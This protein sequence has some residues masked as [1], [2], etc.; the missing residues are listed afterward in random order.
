MRIS[1]L[2][3]VLLLALS[4]RAT[5]QPVLMTAQEDHQRIMNLLHIE[6]LRK[7]ADGSHPDAPNAANY[8][9]TKAKP[10]PDLPD[11]LT[12]RN[13]KKVATARAWWDQ[14]RPQIVEDFDREIYGRVPAVTPSVQWE[15]TATTNETVGDIPVV[16]KK[17]TGHVDNPAYPGIK[18]DIQ[19]SLSTPPTRPARFR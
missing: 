18:V 17:L 14:R 3:L 19:V 2:L 8:D 10:Y 13:G 16:T 4:P 6:S 5:T 7:D 15:V 1:R 9:E 11:P 12:L